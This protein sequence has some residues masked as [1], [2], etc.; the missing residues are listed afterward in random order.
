[1]QDSRCHPK[2]SPGAGVVGPLGGLG[3]PAAVP[4]RPLPPPLRAAERQLERKEP[5]QRSSRPRGGP[6]GAPGGRGGGRGGSARLHSPWPQAAPHPDTG[7]GGIGRVRE[8]QR[9][10]DGLMHVKEPARAGPQNQ[11]LSPRL[12]S[13][14]NNS[15]CS[16]NGATFVGAP[17]KEPRP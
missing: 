6:A 10:G 11:E 8:L 7:R 17:A 4:A 5:G 14:R 15:G 12:P 3:L 2:A 9:C 16:G 1:M 13:R